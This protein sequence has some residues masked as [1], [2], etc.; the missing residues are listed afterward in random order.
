LQTLELMFTTS[1]GGTMRLTISNPKVSLTPAEVASVMDLIIA[2]NVFMTSS[3][4]IVG[5]KAARLVE[6]TVADIALN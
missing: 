1:G 5:K 4:T 2:R 6:Q 3:G